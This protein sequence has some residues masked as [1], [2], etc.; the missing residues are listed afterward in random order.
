MEASSS[1]KEKQ[2]QSNNVAQRFEP[3]QEWE[4]LESQNKF[5]GPHMRKVLFSYQ[6]IDKIQNY[7]LGMIVIA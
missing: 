2:W 4:S 5:M 3:S 6:F 7:K 1:G